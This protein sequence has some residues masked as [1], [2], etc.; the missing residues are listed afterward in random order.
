MKIPVLTFFQP[1]PMS[2]E[3][4]TA[5]PLIPIPLTENRSLDANCRISVVKPQT[6]SV[7][8]RTKQEAVERLQQLFKESISR[9][10]A[11]SVEEVEI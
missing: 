6:I 5:M 11:A 9:L 4:W 10:D 1:S 2:A 8:G 3:E 7:R